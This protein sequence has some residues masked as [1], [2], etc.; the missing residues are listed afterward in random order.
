MIV[1]L[2]TRIPKE[3]TVFVQYKF[4]KEVLGILSIETVDEHFQ[5][6]GDKDKILLV[7][8]DRAEEIKRI[9]YEDGEEFLILGTFDSGKTKVFDS[10]HIEFQIAKVVYE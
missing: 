1:E 7:T 9:I 8:K 5:F 4:S 6:T 10:Q 2:E 3:W